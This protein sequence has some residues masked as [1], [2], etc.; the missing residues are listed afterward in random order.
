ME[1]VLDYRE[2]IEKQK[3]EEFAKIRYEISQMETEIAKLNLELKSINEKICSVQN[4]NE[5]LQLQLYRELLEENIKMQKLL[6]TEKRKSLEEK[7][8]ELKKAQTDRKIMDKLKEKDYSQFVY[9]RNLKEQKEL[10]D[11]SVMKFKR[12]KN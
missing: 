10:D 4:V 5:L 12:T 3:A 2:E 1:K 11:I 8:N 6:L 9:K 7:R